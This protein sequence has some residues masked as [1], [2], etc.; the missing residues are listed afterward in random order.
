MKAALASLLYRRRFEFQA[1]RQGGVRVELKTDES[2]RVV[3]LPSFLAK[4]LAASQDQGRSQQ[5]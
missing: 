2:K 5:A 1:S 3:E 4:M